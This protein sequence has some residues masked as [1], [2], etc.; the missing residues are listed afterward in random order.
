MLDEDIF[1]RLIQFLPAK[2]VLNLIK[3]SKEYLDK[4]NMNMKCT[5]YYKMLEAISERDFYLLTGKI[6]KKTLTYLIKYDFFWKAENYVE[7]LKCVES[8]RKLIVNRECFKKM[9]LFLENPEDG[10]DKNNIVRSYPFWKLYKGQPFD[11]CISSNLDLCQEEKDFLYNTVKKENTHLYLIIS[12]ENEIIN[13]YV[14]NWKGNIYSLVFLSKNQTLLKNILN[15]PTMNLISELT[16]TSE[17]KGDNRILLFKEFLP[18]CVNLKSL[19]LK[20]FPTEKEGYGNF[21]PKKLEK[22]KLNFKDIY[23][24]NT[25]NYM[26]DNDNVIN[27]LEFNF[28]LE[29]GKSISEKLTDFNMDFNYIKKLKNL[30]NL[31]ME[32]YYDGNIVSNELIEGLNG[33]SNLRDLKFV[34]DGNIKYE[35]INELNNPFLESIE[36]S[37]DNLNI[38]KIINNHQNLKNY[39]L[40]Y[41][42]DLPQEEI[43]KLK[44]SKNLENIKLTII[45]EELL[46]PLFKQIQNNTPYPLLELYFRLGIHG[47]PG[48]S[49]KTLQEMGMCFKYTPNLKKLHIIA[50]YNIK[51]GEKRNDLWIENLKYLKNLNYFEL[52][53]YELTIKELELF[54]KSIQNLDYLMEIKILDNCF[55]LEDV[56]EILSKYPLPNMLLKFNIFS[57]CVGDEENEE[58][59]DDEQE[60]EEEEEEEGEEEEEQQKRRRNKKKKKNQKPKKKEKKKKKKEK[61]KKQK[62]YGGQL[63][64]RIWE[65]NKLVGYPD[66]D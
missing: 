38:S 61:K 19:D 11:F 33:L 60:E 14:D 18:S 66:L 28:E 32:F 37:I 41:I 65:T 26:I 54:I 53:F 35:K 25:F 23:I 2:K 62:K 29:T 46:I 59:D 44:Y 52:M 16:I 58:E 4:F 5:K 45:Q 42:G 30:E 15:R 63:L 36:I 47:Y 27:S 48:I 3:Y 55:K 13:W 7:N 43:S 17:L 40:Q 51:K 1:E 12:N 9:D 21:L 6:K 50:A 39:I 10:D 49:N 57:Q 56:K 22:L 24:M 20:E 34:C 8:I 64:S 31:K